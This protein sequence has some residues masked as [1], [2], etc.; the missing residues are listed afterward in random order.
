MLAEARSQIGYHER[1]DGT[2]KYGD[3]FASHH[4]DAYRTGDWCAMGLLWCA[5]QTGQID[6]LGGDRKEWAWV[7]SWWQ[8]WRDQGR[9]TSSPSPGRIVF[10][11]FNRTGDPEHVGICTGTRSDG[12]VTTIEFNTS[13]QCLER[14]RSP[15]DILGYGDPPYRSDDDDFWM[16]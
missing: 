15:S 8:Y 9:S 3:W 4:G 1:S 16:G 13:D 7:P 14:L 10:Y 2:T 11:D 6:V 12:M 5:D